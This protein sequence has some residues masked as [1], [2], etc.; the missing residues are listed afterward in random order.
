MCSSDL[1]IWGKYVEALKRL[2]KEKELV[3]KIN[4]IGNSY[5]DKAN[6]VDKRATYIDISI[7]EKD[8]TRS[9]LPGRPHA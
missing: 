7:D 1:A 3:W 5:I 2:V 6:N 8:L 4:K 9:S